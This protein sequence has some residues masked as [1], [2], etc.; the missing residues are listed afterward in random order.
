MK[1][2]STDKQ[3]QGYSDDVE[4]ATNNLPIDT[5]LV[6]YMPDE[7]F[8][9]KMGYTWANYS[10]TFKRVDDKQTKYHSDSSVKKQI[11]QSLL[12]S[13]EEGCTPAD[14]RVLR[15]ANHEL[16]IE[17]SRLKKDSISKQMSVTLINQVKREFKEKYEEQL[18]SLSCDYLTQIELINE[19]HKKEIDKAVHDALDEARQ[20]MKAAYIQYSSNVEYDGYLPASLFDST[21]NSIKAKQVDL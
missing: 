15:K 11:E 9:D 2:Q 17:I 21:F 8:I 18:D 19:Q 10:I 3:M 5:D 7:V 1:D 6:V 14:A 13:V 4:A 16:A 20:A 12:D